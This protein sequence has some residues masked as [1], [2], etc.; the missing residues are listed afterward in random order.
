LP[1]A[2][3][4]QCSRCTKSQKEK[5]LDVITRLYYQHP[6]KYMA[7]AERYDPNGVY[8]KNFESW[9]DEQN[10]V[11]PR[12][13]IPKDFQR[14]RIP[15]T[16][17]QS[18]TFASQAATEKATTRFSLRTLPPTVRPAATQPPVT[19]RAPPVVITV[20]LTTTTQSPT[21]TREPFRTTQVVFATETE[22]PR[23]SAIPK[24][25]DQPIFIPIPTTAETT[26]QRPTTAF[27]SP[28]IFRT[29]IL[30]TIRTEQP[31]IFQTQAQQTF[32]TETPFRTQPPPLVRIPQ[33][34]FQVPSSS[35]VPR[36]PATESIRTTTFVQRQETVPTSRTVPLII[37]T[38]P[39]TT[40]S[41]GSR[42]QPQVFRSAATVRNRV[43][44]ELNR[45]VSQTI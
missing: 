19:F 39:P 40:R 34:N 37:R 8:T 27:P 38:P 1:D 18:T 7:L 4:N 35:F 5:A 25:E 26:T 28:E 43:D 23:I 11:K 41:P 12:S 14:T 10:A 6:S 45:P 24:R 33:T 15:S 17:V 21:T 9:F 16:W 42:D 22:V 44:P 20:P 30:Q 32:R 3:R 29:E 31:Q 13:S 2:L 36:Q